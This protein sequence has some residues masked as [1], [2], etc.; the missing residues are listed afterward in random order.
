MSG[1]RSLVD[2]LRGQRCEASTCKFAGQPVLRAEAEL[3]LKAFT[4]RMTDAGF[5]KTAVNQA[6]DSRIL[7]ASRH[8]LNSAP[9][10]VAK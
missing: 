2:L 3:S 4:E 5:R 6:P 9:C 10:A 8:P 7:S 1:D